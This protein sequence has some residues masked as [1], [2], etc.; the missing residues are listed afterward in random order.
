MKS[1]QNTPPEDQKIAAKSLPFYRKPYTTIGNPHTR[2][3]I[4]DVVKSPRLS[5]IADEFAEGFSFIRKY[6]RSVTFYGSARFKPSNIHYRDARRLAFALSER[7][8]AIVTGGGPGIMEAANRGARDAGGPSIGLNIILPHEQTLNPYITESHSFKYFFSRK[9]ALSFAAEAYVYFP[10]GFGTLDEFFE[11][12][13][14][15][16]TGKIARVPIILA[17][18]DFWNPLREFLVNSLAIQHGTIARKDLDLFLI[19][20]DH[21]EILK[22]IEAAPVRK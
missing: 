19:T 20:D 1:T 14:L 7:G 21:N 9:T 17:G 18:T 8:Y 22:V 2:E 4:G 5:R 3:E 13:T 6:P 16:Q 12:V 11:V 10:G 15:I